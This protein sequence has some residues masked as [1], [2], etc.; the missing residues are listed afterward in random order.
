MIVLH[1]GALFYFHQAT[2]TSYSEITL[3]Q[4]QF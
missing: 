1:I 4:K 3:W 2:R